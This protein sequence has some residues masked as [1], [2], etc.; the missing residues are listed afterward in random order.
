[1]QSIVHIDKRIVCTI[2]YILHQILKT[3]VSDIQGP[4][5]IYFHTFISLY[6]VEEEAP[7]SSWTVCSSLKATRFRV[8]DLD[9]PEF[10]AGVC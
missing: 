7:S 10:L 8:T 6:L 2:Y 4:G 5:V 3:K 1:M 9:E